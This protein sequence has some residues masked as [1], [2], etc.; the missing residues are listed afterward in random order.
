[1]RLWFVGKK[2]VCTVRCYS[3][4]FQGSGHG[5]GIGY[6][7]DFGQ[8]S[9][10]GLEDGCFRDSYRIVKVGRSPADSKEFCL[11]KIK[12]LIRDHRLFQGAVVATI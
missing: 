6:G 10:G 7:L 8:C 9:L 12:T 5:F 11:E 2:I 3:L 1:M 4:G